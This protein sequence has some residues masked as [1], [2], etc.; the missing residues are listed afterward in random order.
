MSANKITINTLTGIAVKPIIWMVHQD[1]DS[2]YRLRATHT[3][4][5]K[6]DF[7]DIATARGDTKIYRTMKA[8]LHDVRRVDINPVIHFTF[9]DTFS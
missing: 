2:T 1:I 8:L 6:G 5:E 7:F 9:Q 4:P 3:Q